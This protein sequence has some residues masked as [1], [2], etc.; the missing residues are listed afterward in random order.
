MGFVSDLVGGITGA[1]AQADAAQ[2]AANTQAAASQQGI[3]EQRRQ[4]DYIQNLLAPFVSAGNSA[5]TGQMNLAGLNGADAQQTAINLLTRS[6]AYTSLLQQGENSI[7]SN[8][9]ATGGLRSGNTQTALA[10]YSPQLLSQLIQQQY[11]NLGGLTSIGQNSA[12]GAGASAQGT[13]NAITQLLQQQGAAL[14][15]GQ[16]AQGNAAA[17]NASSLLKIG[18]SLLGAF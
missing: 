4:F 17:N 15:G 13:G 5:L 6:P 7:L 1:N 3:A 12:V 9:S 14:A 2:S 18:G 11:Q 8:A 10:Q 16:I